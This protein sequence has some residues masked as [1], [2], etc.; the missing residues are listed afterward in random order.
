M[1]GTHA[2]VFLPDLSSLACGASV[3]PSSA[4]WLPFVSGRSPRA[5]SASAKTA[6]AIRERQPT[7]LDRY[8]AVLDQVGARGITD[9]AA[10]DT[11]GCPLSSV[12]SLRNRLPKRWPN[13]AV[14][15]ADGTEKTKYGGEAQRWRLLVR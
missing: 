10:A 7:Q 8:K 2:R 9:H 12:N 11:L 1:E 14:E 6:R 3:N 15:A 5:R 13:L 4:P